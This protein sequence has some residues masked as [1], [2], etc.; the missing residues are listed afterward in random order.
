M[1]QPTA[2]L[3]KLGKIGFLNVLPIYFPME[4]GIISHPFRIVSGDPAQ[5]NRLMETGKLDMSA[6]SSIVT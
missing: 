3:L 1:G 4:A 6:V 5:L 2:G